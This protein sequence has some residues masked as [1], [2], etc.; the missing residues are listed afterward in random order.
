MRSYTIISANP[1]QDL[2]ARWNRP[3][4]C[5]KAM[6]VLT[7]ISLGILADG[8]INSREALFLESWLR[9]NAE[10]LPNSLIN[11]FIPIISTIAAD[12]DVSD[13][14]LEDLHEL[15]LKS[16]GIDD[17]ELSPE[18]LAEH[19]GRPSGLIFDE[20]LANEIIFFGSQF[21]LSGSFENGSKSMI[22]KKIESYGGKVSNEA[23]NKNTTYVIVGLKGSSQWSMSTM[24]NKIRKGLDMKEDG[25]PIKILPESVLVEA[26]FEK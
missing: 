9:E 22:R 21:V 8:T 14:Q 4:N 24:G 5:R 20:I 26:L 15:L 11:Q 2:V 17:A 16:L 3:N 23:P 19:I 12:G 1:T 13:S 10:E 7:G 18:K 6:D 25:H